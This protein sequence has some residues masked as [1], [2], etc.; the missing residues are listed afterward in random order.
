M[1]YISIDEL[2]YFDFHDAQLQKID[3][4]CDSLRWRLSSL[5]A[6]TQNSQNSFNEDMC[7]KE[8]E[9]I[10]EHFNIEEIVFEAYKVYDSDN[11]LI[12]S[13]EAIAANP[14]EYD[15]I[16]KKTLDSYCYIYSMEELSK[17]EDKKNMVCFN[18]DGGAGDYYITLSFYKSIVQWNEY[19][20]KAWYENEK[21]KKQQY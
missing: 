11:N 12:E 3:I 1:K 16:F 20:G 19:N 15:N 4:D 14:N 9:V 5:N 21:W 18:I 7:I 17:L 10:F 2:N 8:A 6:T 13:V